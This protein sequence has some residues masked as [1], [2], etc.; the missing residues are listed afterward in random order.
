FCVLV[1]AV[2]SWMIARSALSGWPLVGAVFLAYFGL[3]TFMLQIESVVFLPRHLP[4]G[5]VSRL[6]AM[7]AAMGLVAAPAAVWIHR[8]FRPSPSEGRVPSGI[9]AAPG[10][11]TLR[12]AWLAAAYVALYFL[13]GYFIAYRNPDV[14]AYYD[15]ANVGSFAAQMLKVWR[16]APWLFALQVLRGVLWVACV[17]PFI[18][19][20]RG[21]PWELPLL[22]G[23][24]FSVWLVMLLVPNPYMPESVR[25]SHLVETASS[26]FVFG[27]IVGASFVRS[28]ERGSFAAATTGA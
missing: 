9:P 19:S 26:N 25:M 6:F 8:R 13:A 24:A 18:V 28:R 27:C 2:L 7:G 10:E 17:I 1:A 15:D 22:V 4:P 21:R 5:F 20:F 3:G 16:T 23:C 14:V 11:W 12:L